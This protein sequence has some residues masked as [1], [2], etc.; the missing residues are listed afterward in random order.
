MTTLNF[1]KENNEIVL[2]IANASKNFIHVNRAVFI[3]AV[4]L[5][6][7]VSKEFVFLTGVFRSFPPTSYILWR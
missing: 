6:L 1:K 5:T 7:F 4:H 2:Q 3:K